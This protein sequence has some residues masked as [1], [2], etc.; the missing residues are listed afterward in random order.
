MKHKFVNKKFS[1]LNAD[2]IV[3]V[4]S[5]LDDYRKDGYV[6]T[7]RQLY[8]QLVSRDVIP[9]TI[10]SYKHIVDLV[11]NA[12]LAGLVD[13]AMITD[14]GRTATANSHWKNPAEIMEACAQ[15]FQ[16]DKWADQPNYV[17]VEVEKD[18]LSGVLAPVCSELD[19]TF[20]ANK[21]YSSLSAMYETGRRLLRERRFKGK[22]V[23]I[24]YLGDHDPSGIDMTRDVE[25]RLNMFA[26]G[27]VI[28]KRLAL[29][30]PQVEE[31]KPPENPAKETDSRYSGYVE[32]FGE[33]S[34]ELDAIEPRELASIVRNA[35]LEL[36]DEDLWR[37]AVEREEDMKFTIHQYALDET[38][39]SQNDRHPTTTLD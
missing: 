20:T 25:E 29:N 13:W 33:S 28:V 14:R 30:M 32:N 12:R 21:G 26:D 39:R 8:Y 1:S 18:A 2:L 15:Q 19:V 27:D 22:T 10:R 31:L 11:T 5:I 36:R 23:Y 24:L 6:L 7:L 9:N 37:E 4:N 38:V 17:E 16:I 3:T 34:W 35:V